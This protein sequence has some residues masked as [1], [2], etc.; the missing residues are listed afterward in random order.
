MAKAMR[1]SPNLI[2]STKSQTQDQNNDWDTEI[3][4]CRVGQKFPT[5]DQIGPSSN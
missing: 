1:S 5:D 2:I 3:S 4:C